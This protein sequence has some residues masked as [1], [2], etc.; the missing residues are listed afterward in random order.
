MFFQHVTDL[1]QS[2]QKRVKTTRHNRSPETLKSLSHVHFI[3]TQYHSCTLIIGLIGNDL[4]PERTWSSSKSLLNTKLQL[5][6]STPLV[7]IKEEEKDNEGSYFYFE[8]LVEIR[9]VRRKMTGQL[10]WS[11]WF[12]NYFNY[13]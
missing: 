7:I 5:L 1:L 10:F 13:D 6:S 8:S 4:D 9:S 11:D 2:D 12:E 3:M